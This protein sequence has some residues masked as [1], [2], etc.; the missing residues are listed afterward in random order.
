LQRIGAGREPEKESRT[1]LVRE[2]PMNAQSM[3]S[4][5]LGVRTRPCLDMIRTPV[6]D[7]R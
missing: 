6:F 5:R 1:S 7:L 2:S 4:P 3:P